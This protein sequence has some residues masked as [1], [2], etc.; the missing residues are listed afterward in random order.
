V[1]TRA[2]G[3]CCDRCSLVAHSPTH[4]DTRLQACHK[5]FRHVRRKV[6]FIQRAWRQRLQR[7]LE[8]DLD[9]GPPYDHDSFIVQHS[10]KTIQNAFRDMQ[11]A[12]EYYAQKSQQEGVEVEPAR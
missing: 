9:K 8:R 12:N 11:F 10:V 2:A 1:G 6:V 7:I 5:T 4:N 3:G